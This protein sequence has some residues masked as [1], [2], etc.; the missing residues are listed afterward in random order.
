MLLKHT[1]KKLLKKVQLE[2]AAITIQ[3]QFRGWKT[4]KSY[5]EKQKEIENDLKD[6]NAGCEKDEAK[7]EEYL[8]A[9]S[10]QTSIVSTKSSK[11]NKEELELDD[12]RNC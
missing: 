10:Q 12:N 3:K 7:N 6:S 8:N 11:T 4:R 5:K 2:K 1:W 9:D